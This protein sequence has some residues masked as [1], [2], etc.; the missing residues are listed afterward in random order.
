[1]NMPRLRNISSL[2]CSRPSTPAIHASNMADTICQRCRQGNGRS[3]LA[4]GGAL[5]L[6]RTADSVPAAI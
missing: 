3:E 5:R 6:D 4:R 2:T 1:M